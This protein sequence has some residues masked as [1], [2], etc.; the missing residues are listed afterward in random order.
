MPILLI[1]KMVPSYYVYCIDSSAPRDTFNMIRLAAYYISY[2]STLDK[3][4]DDNC[5]EWQENG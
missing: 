2:Q 3:N 1:L 5:Y 4:A